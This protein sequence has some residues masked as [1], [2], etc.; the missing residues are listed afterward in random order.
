MFGNSSHAPCGEALY[1]KLISTQIQQNILTVSVSCVKTNKESNGNSSQFVPEPRV[2]AQ[3]EVIAP[4]SRAD[5]FAL[6][7]NMDSSSTA[8]RG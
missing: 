7:E 2:S 5:F 8:T 6:A 3:V 4:S 1:P